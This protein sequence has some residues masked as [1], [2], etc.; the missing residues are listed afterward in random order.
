MAKNRYINT[1]FWKDNYIIT[2]DPVEKLIFLY[3]LSN[4]QTNIAGVYEINI[5]EI[6]ND[7][8][9]DKDMIQHIFKRFKKDKKVYYEKGYIILVNHLKH[10][11][12]NPKILIGAA[13]IIKLLPDEILKKMIGYGYPMHSLSHIIQLNLTKSNLTKSNQIGLE[14]GFEDEFKKWEKFYPRKNGMNKAKEILQNENFT[15]GDFKDLINATRNYL[16]EVGDIETKYYKI[17]QNFVLEYKT[18]L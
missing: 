13:E 11:N 15:E 14:A 4:S 9:I 3:L 5:K 17:P 2:L 10:Q 16:D 7:T 1:H 18:F 8:G 12:N 6:A